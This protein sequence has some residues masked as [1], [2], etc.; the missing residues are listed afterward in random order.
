MTSS[1]RGLPGALTGVQLMTIGFSVANCRQNELEGSCR[2][3]EVVESV[4]VNQM[5]ANS[6]K[7]TTHCCIGW[8]KK[9]NMRDSL[10]LATCNTSFFQSTLN[11]MFGNDFQVATCH[12]H[13][14]RDQL[15]LMQSLSIKWTYHPTNERKTLTNGR[16]CMTQGHSERSSR[17]CGLVSY[18]DQGSL[19]QMFQE[20][21]DIL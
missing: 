21:R 12:P 18:L 14:A 17:D 3:T 6:I 19:A 20:A 5:A 16:T 4:A 13:N 9:V 7:K 2:H 8:E 10:K 1:P 11:G 15:V